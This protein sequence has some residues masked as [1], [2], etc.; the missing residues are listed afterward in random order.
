MAYGFG[1][2]E[3]N[4]IP[5]PII[6][7]ISLSLSKYLLFILQVH[8]H[9]GLVKL[10]RLNV[11]CHLQCAHQQI[12]SLT[13]SCIDIYRSCKESMDVYGDAVH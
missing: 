13:I 8:E 10:L 6:L 4:T 9:K 1:D 11:N 5:P 3:T 12:N 7:K 2:N